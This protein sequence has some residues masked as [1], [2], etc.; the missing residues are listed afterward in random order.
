[1]HNRETDCERGAGVLGEFCLA[2]RVLVSVKALTSFCWCGVCAVCWQRDRN[3]AMEPEKDKRLS[4]IVGGGLGR[5]V[6]YL[7]VYGRLTEQ[8]SLHPRWDGR[9]ALSRR[10]LFV[11]FSGKDRRGRH[12]R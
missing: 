9:V 2:G 11:G 4:S 7:R 3:Y 1:M 5:G 10:V 6:A 12:V 8:H